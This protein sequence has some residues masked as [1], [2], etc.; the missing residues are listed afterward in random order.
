MKGN[1]TGYRKVIERFNCNI[2][3][4]SFKKLLKK[5]YEFFKGRFY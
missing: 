5:M 1:Q 4:K 3:C 2:D